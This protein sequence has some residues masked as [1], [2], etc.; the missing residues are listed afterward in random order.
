MRALLP[1]AWLAA[2]T[3]ARRLAAKKKK[4]NEAGSTT[5]KREH[6]SGPAHKP[7]TDGTENVGRWTTVEH[8]RFLRGLEIFEKDWNFELC[9]PKLRSDPLTDPQT[10][11]AHLWV[12]PL[13]FF[14]A[15][16]L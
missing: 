12:S 1:W 5:G 11:V 9:Q 6:A 15:P 13:K 8:S 16:S 14:Q 4:G 3:D 2:G 7:G 10:L